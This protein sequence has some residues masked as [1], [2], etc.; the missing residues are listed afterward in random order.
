MYPFVPSAKPERNGPPWSVTK[1]RSLGASEDA[2]VAFLR[3]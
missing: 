2:M 1:P 3:A